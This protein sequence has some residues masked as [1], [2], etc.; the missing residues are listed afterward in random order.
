MLKNDFQDMMFSEKIKLENS[1]HNTLT[2]IW[3][4][5]VYE[6]MC[7]LFILKIQ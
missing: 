5:G 3:K 1:V 2:F 6:Y 7:I 4:M